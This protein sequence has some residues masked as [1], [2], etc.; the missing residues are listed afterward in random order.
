VC[1]AHPVVLDLFG[2]DV[3]QGSETLRILDTR[4]ALNA[5]RMFE[6]SAALLRLAQAL[7]DDFGSRKRARGGLDFDDLIETV[8]RLL[9]RRH[10]ADWVLWKLDGGIAHILLDEAQDTSPAQWRIL[11]A[12]TSDMFA[13]AGAARESTRSLFVVGDQK[14]S[15]YSFQGADPEHFLDQTQQY[16]KRAR[17]AEVD[18]TQPN[19]AMSFRS[20]PEILSYVDAVF[21]A[22]AFLPETPFS[23]QP[24]NA[25][26]LLR[27]TAFR[28]HEHGSVDLWPL[29]PRREP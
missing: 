27:H 11:E 20:A 26:D 1:A 15:I 24:P 21:D 10:A 25:A 4:N 23:L 3:P 28:R 12:L 7:F 29:E 22:G 9:T 17:E 5:R 19:L 14:Q 18:F 2:V 6:R 16:E 8:G 13:G